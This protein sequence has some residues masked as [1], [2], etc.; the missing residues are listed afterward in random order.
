MIEEEGEKD[1]VVMKHF[2]TFMHDYKLHRGRKIFCRYCLQSFSREKILKCHVKDCFKINGKQM[3][4]M[5]KN[6][7][8][9]RFKKRKIKSPVMIYADFESI[10]V[11]EDNENQNLYRSHT[12]KYQKHVACSCGY[13]LECVDDKFS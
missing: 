11:S 12:N 3:T 4:K 8:Y 7:G 6:G 1:Y 10:L 5:S 9:V 2:S 13:K